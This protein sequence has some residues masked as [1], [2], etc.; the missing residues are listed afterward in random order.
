MTDLT[1]RDHVTG[2]PLIAMVLGAI[3][4][5]TGLTFAL[6]VS[7]ASFMD[8]TTG[9][10]WVVMVGVNVAAWALLSLSIYHR[11][12]TVEGIVRGRRG[13]LILN[14]FCFVVL[15]GAPLWPSVTKQIAR[16]ELVWSDYLLILVGGVVAAVAMAGI[17]R[18]HAATEELE[19][20]RGKPGATTQHRM[21]LYMILQDH[22]Q[23]FF[24]IL[25][26]MISL[27]T[28][29]LAF[30]IKAL[31]AEDQIVWV[32]GLYYT[33]LLALSYAPTQLGLVSSG[34]TLRHELTGDAPQGAAEIEGWLQRRHELDGLLRLSEGPLGNLKVGVFVVS[35]LLT[36]V[37][38]TAFDQSS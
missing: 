30:G 35:P 31:G 20:N 15:F 7:P 16:I 3:G 27:G 10:A 34:R 2:S 6:S 29:A 22:L 23:A 18:I 36:S 21:A 19:S 37:L 25:G 28:L 12:R 4:F 11:A 38:S 5:I 26:T 14:V 8:R 9:R 13:P 32:Y 33:A 1:L 24:W 17:W